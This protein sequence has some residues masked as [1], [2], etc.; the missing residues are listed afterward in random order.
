M[1]NSVTKYLLLIAN[2]AENK[3]A[4]S[5]L[6]MTNPLLM[7]INTSDVFNTSNTDI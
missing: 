7:Q 1:N 5:E 2:K 6:Q 3:S 4:K